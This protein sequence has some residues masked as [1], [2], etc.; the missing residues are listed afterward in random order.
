M[1]LGT[2]R[3]LAVAPLAAIYQPLLAAS[4]GLG[5]MSFAAL[6]RRAGLRAWQAAAGGALSLGATLLYNYTLH[7]GIKEILV[8]ALLATT[9]ALALE[10][11]DRGLDARVVALAALVV[12]AMVSVF[13]VAVGA[14]VVVVAVLVLATALA[15]PSRPSAKHLGRILALG[16]AVGLI[17]AL[18]SLKSIADFGDFA[19]SFFASSGGAST[20]YL[21]HLLRPLPISEASGVWLARDYRAP[22][23]AAAQLPNAV[24]V[25]VV[26]LLAVAGGWFELRGRRPSGMVLFLAGAIP[27]LALA[28]RLGPYA[29][30]KLYVVLTPTV[31]LLAAVGAFRLSAA[32]RAPSAW[33]VSQGCWRSRS[34]CSGP[35][36]WPTAARAWR[37]SRACSR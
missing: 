33:R 19:S 36:P 12:I 13:S 29:D 20:G 17:A 8:V 27:V 15:G 25:V 22:V 5:A 28:A 1:F 35:T 37:R 11:A 34:G 3:P 24:L 4:A 21:G 9:T 26:A 2:L 18:P 14:A 16:L 30:A 10:S 32:D 31:V 7:G 23:T 6:A